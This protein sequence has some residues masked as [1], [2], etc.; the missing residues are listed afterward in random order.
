MAVLMPKLNLIRPPMLKETILF[1]DPKSGLVQRG[2]DK[3]S[4]ENTKKYAVVKTEDIPVEKQSSESTL[5]E[6][7]ELID[8]STEETFLP[9]GDF[10]LW[11]DLAVSYK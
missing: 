10:D 11:S 4:K 8:W 3:V 6:S 1:I 2:I 5:V 7:I 9:E